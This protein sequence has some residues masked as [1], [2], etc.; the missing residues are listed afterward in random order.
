MIDK[1]EYCVNV[2]QQGHNIF[3][4]LTS[5]EYKQVL[6]QIKHCILAT[7][8]ARF[9]PYRTRLQH[10]VTSNTFSPAN[11]DHRLVHT[12]LQTF[13]LC[14]HLFT[15]RTLPFSLILNSKL[16]RRALKPGLL[17]NV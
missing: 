3:S 10:L 11:P 1:F 4:Q 14:F 16:H 8:L 5:S 6:G 17:K 7:D 9:F 12:L 2:L 13:S 15:G